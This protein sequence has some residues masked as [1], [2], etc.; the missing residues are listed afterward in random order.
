[1]PDYFYWAAIV[2]AAL[3]LLAGERSSRQ[4]WVPHTGYT[5]SAV[6]FMLIHLG[7]K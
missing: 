2:V 5:W 7:V 6:A 1:M 4:G 3:A